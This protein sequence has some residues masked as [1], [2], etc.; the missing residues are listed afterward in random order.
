M[1]TIF[2]YAELSTNI[3]KY[4]CLYDIVN[5]RSVSKLMYD[6]CSYSFHIKTD[7]CTLYISKDSYINYRYINNKFVVYFNNKKIASCSSITDLKLLG[8]PS[9]CYTTFLRNITSKDIYF[10]KEKI[11][12]WYLDTYVTSEVDLSIFDGYYDICTDS[13]E[14]VNT[15]YK[16]A[17]RGRNI[18]III[19]NMH[20]EFISQIRNNIINNNITNIRLVYD[21]RSISHADVIISNNVYQTL[22]CDII[23]PNYID[24]IPEFPYTNIS[25]GEFQLITTLE[26]CIN[27]LRY[28]RSNNIWELANNIL[29]KLI[30]SSYINEEILFEGYLTLYYYANSEVAEEFVINYLDEISITRSLWQI[31]EHWYSD[32]FKLYIDRLAN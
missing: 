14:Y 10:D 3:S 20:C 4:L 1:E 9:Y 17:Y 5:L 30:M 11:G 27:L 32:M 25:I 31:N 23:L 2:D 28:Y 21:I 13:V 26:K 6:R 29:Q 16:L 24:Y 15:M 12:S 22:Q 7:I 19:D 18:R 8:L